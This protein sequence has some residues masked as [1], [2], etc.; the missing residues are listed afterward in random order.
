MD[1][2]ELRD[3]IIAR[4]QSYLQSF[5]VIDDARISQ[6]VAD[7][8]THGLLWP[9]PLLQL[10]PSFEP[11]AFIDSLVKEQ[12]LHEECS[13]IFRRG[14]DNGEGQPLRL[15]RHQ[16]D[17]VRTARTGANYVLTTGTG[18]GKSLAY[19]V[20]I[21]D[22]ILR[23]GSGKGI[24]AIVVYPMNAL[25]NSQADELSKFLCQG[26]ADR[27]WPVTFRRY[28]GQE[29]DEERTDIIAHPPDILLTN[30]VMLELILTRPRES[31]LIQSAKGLPFLVLD[32]LH[33]YRGRQGADVALLVRRLRDRLASPRMQCVGTSATLAGIGTWAEQ[34][35]EVAA[36]ASKLFGSVVHPE[37]VIG[38]TLRRTTPGTNAIADASFTQKL[39]ERLTRADSRPPA[40]FASFVTDPLAIWI[41]TVFGL[42]AE[43]DSGRLVRSRPRSISGPDGAAREL[44][45]LTGHSV[46][47][48]TKAIRD[49]LLAG[50]QCEPNPETGFPPFAF[51]LHQF[52]S[53]GQR[54]YSSLEDTAQRYNT[55]C[56]QQFVP[57]DRN[58]SLFPLAFC[59]ECGQEY[60]VVYRK[61]EADSPIS[62]FT[63]RE[64]GDPATDEDGTPGFLALAGSS[65][66]PT[67]A[68]APL[69]RLPADWLEE[70]A[71][72]L[73]VRGNRK[74]SIPQLVRISP[75]GITSPDGREFHWLPAPFRFCLK[76]GV[77]YEFQQR[78]DFGKL[79]PLGM[80]ARSTAT[81]VLSLAAIQHLREK[82]GLAAQA[83]KLL[84]FTDNRQDASLQAGH[85]NDFVGVG[86][87]RSALYSAVAASP[88][89]V[90]HEELTLR[91]FDALHLPM[92]LYAA[93]PEVKF[94][95]LDDTRKAL[96]QVLGY[97]LY[98]DLRRGWRVTAPNLEQCGLLEIHYQSLEELAA[99]Q[100]EWATRHAALATATP[101]TRV[102]VA[103]TALDFLRRELAIKVDYLNKGYQ[104][105]IEQQS[106]QRLIPPWGLDE[107]ERM[108]TSAVAYPRHSTPHDYKGDLY[109]SPLTGFGRY[110]R[111]PTTFLD[112]GAKLTVADADEVIKDLLEALRVAGLV[113]M[114]RE[115]ADDDQ[116][117]G[118]QIP[119]SAL[120]WKRG[121]GQHAFHDPIRIP[122]LPEDGA[123]VNP[124]FVDFYKNVGTRLQ[125][126]EAHEH[127]AQ[128]SNEERQ[129]RERRF[130][131]G[132]LPILFCSPTMELGVDIAEL[133]VVNMRNV[134][135]TPANY[136]Q[137]S[138]RAGRSGQPA[139]VFTY[140]STGSPHDQYFFKRP[141]DMVSG[142]VATPRL[143][144]ANEDLIRSHMQAVWLPET[145]LDLGRSL[146]DLLDCSGGEPTFALKDQVN[147]KLHWPPAKQMALDRCRRILASISDELANS[148]WYSE[149]WAEEV[150]TQA[151]LRFDAACD[152]W[153]GMYKAA[154]SQAKTQTAII[155][156]ATRT[157]EDRKQAERLRKEAESQMELLR[158]GDNRLVS[159]F[160][161]YRYFASEGFLPGYNF[162][163]LPLSAF[164]PARRAHHQDEYL[165]RPRFLAISEFGP[166][167]IIYHEGS[168]YIINKVILPVRE[169]AELPT[170]RAKLCP[171]C[172]Y[173]HP[174][175]QGDGVD[176]CERCGI[177]LTPPL[178]Q[179]LR[180]Q[181]VSTRRRDKISCD[182]EERMRMG[183]EV[184]TG[185]RFAEHGSAPSH[186]VAKVLH[187]GGVLA[188]LTF[189]P[190]ATLWR[191]NLGWRRRKEY[192]QFGFV[193][194]TERGY[195]GKDDLSENDP[196][197][198]LSAR[199]RRV[200]PYVED[201]RN[202][203][204]FKPSADVQITP[205][206]MALKNAVQAVYQLEDNELA[207]EA[208]PN[209]EAPQLI[210][211]YES[212]E[213]G[214]GVLRRLLDDPHAL[215]EV[216]RKA[217]EICHFDPDTGEDRRRSER[218]REDCEAACYDC[219]LTYQNQRVHPQLDR[220]L[221][222]DY[223]LKLSQSKVEAAP[224]GDPRPVHLQKLQNMCDS[225]LEKDWLMLLETKGLRL[226]TSAQKYISEANT[227]AD[228]YYEEQ[229]TAIYVDGPPH[230]YPDQK[231]KDAQINTSLLEAG[232]SCIRFHHAMRDKWKDQVK[233]APATFGE[234]K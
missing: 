61:E 145:T 50:Y 82:S 178:A 70:T 100:E 183:F 200:I 15:Y 180:L 228:F 62:S 23:E 97:R 120:V 234:L 143:D 6:T 210:L 172:G 65:G 30:Y 25:A 147:D 173:L 221:I 161:S 214:A 89:G 11:G 149:G 152:R 188:T 45:D 118:Y 170:S 46:E 134:P 91:V 212:A 233:A 123:R 217:L 53:S 142:A 20:P 37:N 137:R 88:Q 60:Y 13:K 182:E 129:N 219:L 213:G 171:A 84:S 226:P 208:L 77:S 187:A 160:Y 222:C 199:Q 119:A 151:A 128:V 14:K 28:T 110:L 32:E 165:S 216:A 19:I 232:I 55:V 10:N 167:A 225:Q 206:Q 95:A 181:N 7:G 153:R 215:P 36:V 155:H 71:K 141:P 138:G 223:L 4:Y 17:A 31:K 56:P 209:P 164:I 186:R 111:R 193:L 18:S 81:T 175:V 103:K 114:V 230:D 49:T 185:V 231:A 107:N 59:R 41:E 44:A 48:C 202:C 158:A 131:S 227:C 135:P 64:L 116:V 76:C 47:I 34:Q 68:D 163:R 133:N 194:D 57:G 176:L 3:H 121:D 140:C 27:H 195:W 22:H 127:T 1:V 124:F 207:V 21:V 125:G 40:D 51:R 58:R 38:E 205:L 126:I 130:R 29:S 69:D 74:A 42:T 156:D 113:E 179:L 54:A 162:P 132:Q 67:T 9:D 108:E 190:A 106:R 168:R 2:F 184:I 201:H 189:G 87:L 191:V 16:E 136:A 144:L 75:K 105:Q 39:C 224:G 26:Y 73:E 192:S 94:A 12:V 150:L 33:T 35:V 169:G 229:N 83:K 24:R 154:L 80:E 177:P 196:D 218:G 159:D 102:E 211:L 122:N 72:G 203:L 52:V 104:E 198:P 98:Q 99:A 109:L 115:P 86:L 146:T 43:Q 197:D 148:G 204:L 96:R 79:N 85:F 174:V 78:T 139:L 8:L 90:T 117:P 5:V 112:Y 93:D 157:Q 66:W 63:E 220:H 166:R 92:E 101:A